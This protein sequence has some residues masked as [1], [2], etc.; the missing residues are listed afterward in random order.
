MKLRENCQ[1][2][3]LPHFGPEQTCLFAKP[4]QPDKRTLETW[5]DGLF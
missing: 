3:S 2:V 4:F 5:D 1:L